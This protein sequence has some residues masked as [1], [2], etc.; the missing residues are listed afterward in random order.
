MEKFKFRMDNLIKNMVY[1]RKLTIVVLLTVVISM[2][3]PFMT[4]SNLMYQAREDTM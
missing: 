3:F 4:I 1:N 2:F